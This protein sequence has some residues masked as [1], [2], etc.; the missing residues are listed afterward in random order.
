MAYSLTRLPTVV[1][2]MCEYQYKSHFMGL[3]A[4]SRE[5]TQVL[6]DAQHVAGELSLSNR[7]TEISGICLINLIFILISLP[8][9]FSFFLSIRSF[10]FRTTNCPLIFSA[11]SRA[12][13]DCA[14]ITITIAQYSV[15]SSDSRTRSQIALFTLSE[16]QSNRIPAEFL[17]TGCHQRLELLEQHFNSFFTASW[18]QL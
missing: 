5:W 10:S 11:F 13:C 4:M 17:E 3:R 15:D 6:P 9:F 1:S 12:S 2:R 7:A 14:A 16:L 8:F 18:K